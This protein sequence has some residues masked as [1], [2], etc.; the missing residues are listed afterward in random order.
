MGACLSVEVNTWLLIARRLF[1][2][3]GHVVFSF[4]AQ[5]PGGPRQ[6]KIISVLFYMTWVVIRL[7]IYPAVFYIVI[8]EYVKRADKVHSHFNALVPAPIL[9]AVFCVLNFK[10]S[11]DLLLSKMRKGKGKGDGKSL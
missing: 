7:F 8:G 9:Q 1:N 2:R 11:Y 5:T 6:V 3:D 4:S 10:W